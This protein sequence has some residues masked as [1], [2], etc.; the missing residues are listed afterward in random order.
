MIT[1]IDLWSLC[2][3]AFLSVFILLTLLAT[4]MQLITLL[5]P[6]RRPTVESPLVAAISSAVSSLY[7]GSRVTRIE[8]E[9]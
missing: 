7:P 8:E 9:S 6:E 2:C 4:A 1:Q 5:F 3:V